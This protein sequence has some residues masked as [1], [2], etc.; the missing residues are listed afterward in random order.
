MRALLLL[1]LVA[2][3]Y[4][5]A[6]TCFWGVCG[7]KWPKRQC[8]MWL[9]ALRTDARACCT[10]RHTCEASANETLWCTP[11]MV[12]AREQVRVFGGEA[13]KTSECCHTN[14]CNRA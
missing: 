6:L 4:A 8:Q 7:A 13:N 11:R 3:T 1:L 12:A 10:R 9:V 5:S 14:K 2:P